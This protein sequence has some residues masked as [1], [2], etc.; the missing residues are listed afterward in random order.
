MNEGFYNFL[1][2]LFR[3]KSDI[4]IAIAI[5]KLLMELPSIFELPND[6]A[7][8]DPADPPKVANSGAIAVEHTAPKVGATADAPND[9]PKDEATE[10]APAAAIATFSLFVI[11]CRRFIINKLKSTSKVMEKLKKAAKVI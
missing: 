11:A 4:T 6:D 9:A 7:A 2:I 10:P 5:I 3:L 1:D 8:I